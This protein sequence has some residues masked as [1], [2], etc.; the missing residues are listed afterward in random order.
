MLVFAYG[1]PSRGDDALGPLLL[2][3][4]ARRQAAGGLGDVDLLTDFQLQVE[5]ALDLVDRE[6]VV[7]V[8]AS[9]SAPEPFSFGPVTP[10]RDASYTTHAMSAAAVL[11][12]FEQLNRATPPATWLMAIRGYAFALG[13]PVGE[14]ANNNLGKATDYLVAALERSAAEPPWVRCSDGE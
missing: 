11:R 4:L 3:E 13:A 5:H 1:N 7:F 12:V 2:E 9:L 8:D 14:K 10:E 6:R